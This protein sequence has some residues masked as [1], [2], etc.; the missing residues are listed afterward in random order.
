MKYTFLQKIN[1][2]QVHVSKD[3]SYFI[4]SLAL[5]ELAKNEIL[6]FPADENGNIVEYI[7]S[8]YCFKY[9]NIDDWTREFCSF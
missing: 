3:N 1:K 8:D 5:S 6:I 9:S 4:A 2:R 7:E